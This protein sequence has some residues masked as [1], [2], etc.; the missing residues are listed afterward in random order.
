MHYNYS[1]QLDPNP[2]LVSLDKVKFDP[3][4]E[5]HRSRIEAETQLFRQKRRPHFSRRKLRL[6]RTNR[7]G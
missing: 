2:N 4:T 6:K 5:E 3:V 7:A 1:Y